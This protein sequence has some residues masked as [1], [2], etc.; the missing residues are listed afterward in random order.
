MTQDQAFSASHPGCCDEDVDCLLRDTAIDS[1][2]ESIGHAEIAAELA[3][4][5]AWNAAELADWD[6]C[7]A[8][9]VWLAAGRIVDEIKA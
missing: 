4:Y 7:K 6:D 2:L 9:I 8:Y 3:E 5:G 1:Q